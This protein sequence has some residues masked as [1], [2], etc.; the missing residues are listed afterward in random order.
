[1]RLPAT[2]IISRIYPAAERAAFAEFVESHHMSRIVK[3]FGL[4]TEFACVKEFHVKDLT[5]QHQCYKRK[6]LR[7]HFSF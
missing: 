1:M 2:N 7:S 4:S 5:Q 3:G 6:C